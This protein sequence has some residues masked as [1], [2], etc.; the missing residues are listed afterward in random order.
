[1]PEP[2][3]DASVLV[4][5]DNP[6]NLDLLAQILGARGYR[7]RAVPSGAM[8]LSSARLSPPDLILLDIK[9][10]DLDGYATCQALK[11]EAATRDIP[12]IFISALDEAWDKVK[13]FQAGGSD[14]LTKPFYAEEV[15][16]RARHQILLRR[17]Q[18]SLQERSAS[19]AAANL[20]LLELGKFKE[21]FTAMVVHDLRSPLTSIGVI[22][23]ALPLQADPAAR[24]RLAG[25]GQQALRNLLD[26]V[27]NL[28]EVSRGTEREIQVQAEPVRLPD[29][30][31]WARE[32]FLPQLEAR[33][34]RL[35]L[36]VAPDLPVLQADPKLVQR[37]VG[38]LVGNAIKFTPVGGEIGL[39]VG[40]LACY[41]VEERRSWLALSVKDSG[42]GIPEQELPFIFDPFHQVRVKDGNA[43]FGLGLA[44]VQRIMA[45]HRGRA[46][47]Q[48]REGAG[49]TFTLLFPL[50]E[51]GAGGAPARDG[52]GISG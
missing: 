24:E 13:A 8:A 11:A 32:A 49:S 5:D 36:A 9:M 44:I 27:N 33:R 25:L 35:D 28:M 14:Y 38:N 1:M 16:V 20:E 39:H 29:L 12:V 6:A 51:T 48:S 17:L 34:L 21:R 37:A 45:A 30:V 46:T 4:V 41:G 40:V 47:V 31:Q 26:L 2:G 23:E 22:L 50:P 15:L 52:N 3:D 19:L 18:A 10:P 7:V 43:G 42:R